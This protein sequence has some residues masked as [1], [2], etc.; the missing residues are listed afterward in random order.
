MCVLTK[1]NAKRKERCSIIVL[2]LKKFVLSFS[3]FCKS[4]SPTMVKQ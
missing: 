1:K 2:Y 3:A 4:V